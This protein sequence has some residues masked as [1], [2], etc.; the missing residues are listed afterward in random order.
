MVVE[1]DSLGE[2][3]RTERERRHVSLQDISAATKIQLKFLE[4]LEEDRYDDL[5][6]APFV[7]GFLRAYAQC[8]DLDPQHIIA[9]YHVQHRAQDVPVGH[10]VFVSHHTA[11][12]RR[13]SLTGLAGLVIVLGLLVGLIIHQF[14]SEHEAPL[15]PP[16]P[17]PAAEQG[18]A[19]PALSHMMTSVDTAPTPQ[20][21]T[22]LPDHKLTAPVSPAPTEP[23]Q[24]V[25]EPVSVEPPGS[26]PTVPAPQEHAASSSPRQE[27]A[28]PLVLQVQALQD[29]W[30]R[31]EIDGQKR[32]AL[33]LTAGKNVRWQ[34]TERFVLTVGNVQGTRLTL[35]GQ[36]IPLP[37]TRSNVVRNFLLTRELLN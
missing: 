35:N 34:A 6:P 36:E 16:S 5:P 18:V 24:A 17:E 3:L 11:R 7:M 4:A 25:A 21:P 31:V 33:L 13:I 14:R 1:P 28:T 22:G 20:V 30:L 26:P 23:P 9:A 10:R 2:Y 37:Q 8:L 27:A 15:P 29:T 32:H 19:T 12:S